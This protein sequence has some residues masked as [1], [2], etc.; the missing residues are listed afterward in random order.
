MHLKNPSVNDKQLASPL[1][2][3]SYLCILMLGAIS[4]CRQVSGGVVCVVPPPSP[5]SPGVGFWSFRLR[6]TRVSL[7]QMCYCE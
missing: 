1:D 5:F 4:N 7:S 6:A 3:V 2:C